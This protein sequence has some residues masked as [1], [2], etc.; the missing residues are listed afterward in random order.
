MFK[1]IL[2]PVDGSRTSDLGLNL[3]MGM[4]REG[5][6]TL[7]LLHVVPQF[8]F[9]QDAIGG[10]VYADRLF[11]GMREGG[12]Q[13]IGKA[14]QKVRAKGLKYRAIL[15]EEPAARVSEVIVEQA[16]KMKADVIVL[17]THGRRGLD[18]IVMGSDAEGVVRQAPVPVLLVRSKET[19][20]KRRR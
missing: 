17:G 2:V 13:I 15:V 9:M 11:E 5:D 3:A 19:E 14:E 7:Y 10:A 18:R 6:S 20:K 12:R 8:I 16:K 1:K 4:A